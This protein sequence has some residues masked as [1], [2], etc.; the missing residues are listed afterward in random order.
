[1]A[2]QVQQGNALA[3]RDRVTVRLI[4]LSD[5]RFYW[6]EED[7]LYQFEH[8]LKGLFHR[9]GL[10]GTYE[11]KQVGRRIAGDGREGIT[12]GRATDFGI[13]IQ[14]EYGRRPQKDIWR[15]VIGDKDTTPT[16]ERLTRALAGE[17]LPSILEPPVETQPVAIA[18]EE[19]IASGTEPTL[20]EQSADK[21]VAKSLFERDPLG[22]AHCLI[23]LW[24]EANERNYVEKGALTNIAM[25]YYPE[26]HDKRKTPPVHNSFGQ[27]GFIERME[28]GNYRLILSPIEMFLSKHHEE[29]LKSSKFWEKIHEIEKIAA[30]NPKR[31]ATADAVRT[32]TRMYKLLLKKTE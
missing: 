17:T 25:E 11:V 23:F 32:L 16:L 24:G 27:Q 18:Q 1:M 3:S 22:M 15:V 4:T 8:E 2:T 30:G 14:A 29:L 5:Y 12:F 13:E 9:A 21:Q 31:T 7:L 28:S 6:R 19:Q 26:F 20:A 10:R